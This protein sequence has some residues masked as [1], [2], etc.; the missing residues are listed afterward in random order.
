MRIGLETIMPSGAGKDRIIIIKLDLKGSIDNN[1]SAEFDYLI[2][3]LINGGVKR[4]IIDINDLQ[5]ID[6]TGIGLLILLTKKLRKENGQIAITRFTAQILTILKPINIEKFIE[7]FPTVEEGINY[8]K[9]I[10]N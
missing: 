9:S 10:E 7:F 2:S 4:I 1:N 6:S 8:L 5:Y 3:T